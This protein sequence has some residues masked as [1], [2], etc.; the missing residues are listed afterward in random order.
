MHKNDLEI[1]R[2][3]MDKEETIKIYKNRG[4]SGVFDRERSLYSFQR[5]K[6]KTEAGF[7]K[8][9]IC[10]TGNRKIKILDVA[11]GTGRMLSEVL[12][13]KKD[14]EYT[15]LDTSA[16]MTDVLKK[17]ARLMGREK[18]I[19]VVIGDAAKMPFN[20]SSFDIVFS[21]HLLW[22][23]EKEE[24][25]KVIKEMAR[26]AKPGGFIIFDALNSGFIWEKTK[27]LIGRKKEQGLH[28]ISL[29]EAKRMLGNPADISVKKLSDAP[30]KNGILYGAFNIIN[31]AESFMPNMLYHMLYI[32]ARK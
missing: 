24:Q 12:S 14:I 2:D 5:Y 13:S 22:H 27:G 9:A 3:I 28:K 30:I 31:R 1:R 26:V 20:S 8:E 21:F 29:G 17:K 6:H 25:E 23:I 15:G 10:E 16:A 4:I 11:C 18:N 32:K 7:L 19:R